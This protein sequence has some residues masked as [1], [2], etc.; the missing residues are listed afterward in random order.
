MA[1][2]RNPELR[3]AWDFVEH[4]GTSIFLTGK[5]GT[6]KT[7]F[8][9]TIVEKSTKQMIVVAPTGVAA[10]NA[11]GVTIH[12]FFQ[13]DLAPHIPGSKVNENNKF[14]KEK[15]KIIAS[16]DLL[17]IDEL[18]HTEGG[19]AGDVHQERHQRKIE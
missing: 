8:L 12:S 9:R 13:L 14:S 1:S 7:T 10:I 16:M 19:G 2:E 6:G 5:A 3:K 11:G 17:I 15:R 4:T 18:S